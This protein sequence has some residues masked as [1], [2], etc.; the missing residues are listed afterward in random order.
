MVGLLGEQDCGSA[1]RTFRALCASPHA[2]LMAPYLDILS[3]LALRHIRNAATVGFDTRL[4]CLALLADIAAVQRANFAPY[5]GTRWVSQ[6]QWQTLNARC[7]NRSS[8]E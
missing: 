3:E 6:G 8:T 5:L 4:A 1:L 2:A 7:I